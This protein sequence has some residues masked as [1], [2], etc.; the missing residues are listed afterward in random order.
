M[1]KSAA[2]DMVFVF[3]SNRQGRH[4]AGAALHAKKVYGAINGQPNGRQGNAYGIITK[5]LR[6]GEPRVSIDEVEQGVIEFL[7]HAQENNDERFLMTRI[8]CGLAGFDED[9]IID[10]F[11][12]HSP[13][14]PDNV[15]FP[16]EWA[17]RIADAILEAPDAS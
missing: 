17:T 11:I 9:K 3:G 16:H 6:F 5:E 15:F 2:N 12:R 14:I 7:T 13:M 8:G 10:I 4:G 1:T